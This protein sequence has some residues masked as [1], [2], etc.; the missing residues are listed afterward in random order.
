[1]SYYPEPDSHI[2]DKV[3]VLLELSNYTTKK[4][5]ENA[6]G[7]GTS[8]LAAKKDFIAL[9]VEVDM[10][11]VNDLI[12]FSTGLNNL[13]AEVDDSDVGKLKTVP[14]DLQK[15]SDVVDK[16]VVKNTKFNTLNTKLNNLEKNIPDAPTLIQINQCNTDKQNLQKKNGDVENKIPHTTGLATIAVLNTKI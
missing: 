14:K 15:L 9:K 7:V 1:M 4:E 6:A 11:D 16:E 5:F 13:K 12:K 3:K 8:D 10:L 2:K